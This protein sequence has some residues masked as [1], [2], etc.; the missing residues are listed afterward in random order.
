MRISESRGV[1][2]R[3]PFE[4]HPLLTRMILQERRS[5]AMSLHQAFVATPKNRHTAAATLRQVNA[6]AERYGFGVG[7]G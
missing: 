2:P 6:A 1:R 4:E 7:L 3:I 5:N